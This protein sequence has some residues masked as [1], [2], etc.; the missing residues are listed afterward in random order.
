MK[1]KDIKVGERYQFGYNKTGLV[2]EVGVPMPRTD[3]WGRTIDHGQRRDG[4]KM[5]EVRTL[6]YRTEEDP[7]TVWMEA[8]DREL[9]VRGAELKTTEHEFFEKVRQRRQKERDDQEG[10]KEVRQ[11]V[12]ALRAHGLDVSVSN[13]RGLSLTLDSARQVLRAIEEVQRR[14][15][16]S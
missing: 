13:H 14:R 7:N 6:S 2:K 10:L 16:S 12:E 11:L 1:L 3:R 8:W 4:V 15:L 5:I 9:V